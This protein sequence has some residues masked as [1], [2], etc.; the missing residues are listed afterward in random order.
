MFK[1]IT[2]GLFA[3]IAA[4]ALATPASA[5]NIILRDTNGTFAAS[6][7]RGQAALFAFQ[8]AANFWNTTLTNA[9]LDP[10]VNFGFVGGAMRRR[11]KVRVTYA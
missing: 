1:K 5:A 2:L 7:S 8:K 4:C 10:S 11:G 6:G 9:P 3:S